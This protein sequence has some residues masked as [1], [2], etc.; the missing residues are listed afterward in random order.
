[1]RL[2]HKFL[3]AHTDTFT[4]ITISKYKDTVKTITIEALSNISLKL[5]KYK[6]KFTQNFNQN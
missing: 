6:K 1:M 5:R 3:F 2:Y 4:N